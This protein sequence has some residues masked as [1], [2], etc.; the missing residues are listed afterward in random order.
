MALFSKLIAF[1]DKV[2]FIFK[3]FDFNEFR[4]LA[5]TDIEYMFISCAMAT[6]KLLGIKSNLRDDIV[7]GFVHEEFD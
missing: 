2:E 1:E 6:Y 3:L 5:I 7:V 4:S